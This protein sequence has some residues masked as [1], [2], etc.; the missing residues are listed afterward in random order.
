MDNVPSSMIFLIVGVILMVLFSSALFFTMQN[1]LKQEN[2]A[3]SQQE[4]AVGKM[5]ESKFEKYAGTQIT[6]SQLISIAKE[7]Y[8]EDV[9]MVIQVMDGSNTSTITLQG[10]KGEPT[11]NLS[12]ELT[13]I[14]EKVDD[15]AVYTGSITYSADNNEIS[16]LSFNFV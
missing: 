10:K 1:G 11:T 13:L 8:Y 6:G 5:K 16:V 9:T 2:N 3:A 15:T 4:E 12:D 7:M 14:K